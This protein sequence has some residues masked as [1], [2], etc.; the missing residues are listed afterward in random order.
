MGCNSFFDDVSLLSM[1]KFQVEISEKHVTDF[2]QRWKV[3][4]L[5]LFGSVVGEGFMPDSDIDVL[6]SFLPDAKW[7]LFDLIK[8]EDELIGDAMLS[9]AIERQLEIIGE[10]ARRISSELQEKHTEIP[11]RS[12]IGLRNILIQEYGEVHMDRLWLIATTHVDE[13]VEKLEP[14]IP[15]EPDNE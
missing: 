7:S 1:I 2:C 13:L 8:M 10:A 14:L 11:W 15:P 4:E 9:S 6:V 3:R 12:I 5:S